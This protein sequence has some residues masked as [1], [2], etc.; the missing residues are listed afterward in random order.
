MGTYFKAIDRFA[1]ALTGRVIRY[2][3]LV[4]A[5]AVDVLRHGRREG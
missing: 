4:I 1:A 3:W 2:R 5:A